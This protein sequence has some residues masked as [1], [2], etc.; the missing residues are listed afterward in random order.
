MEAFVPRLCSEGCQIKH[1]ENCE[2]CFGF[3]MAAQPMEAFV[4]RA[5]EAFDYA[6]SGQRPRGA[7][8]LLN[9]EV[10]GSGIGGAASRPLPA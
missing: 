5:G 4:V 6:S 3:G 7:K 8:V 1:I 9:C 2:A 10:C